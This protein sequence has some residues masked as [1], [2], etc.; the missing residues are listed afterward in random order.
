MLCFVHFGRILRKRANMESLTKLPFFY[1][2]FLFCVLGRGSRGLSRDRR[3]EG[4]LINKGRKSSIDKQ[5]GF[6]S[7]RKASA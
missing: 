5:L 1:V 2:L 3:K 7:H 6:K 4:S